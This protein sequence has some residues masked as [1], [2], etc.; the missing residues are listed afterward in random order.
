MPEWFKIFLKLL[1]LFLFILV[2]VALFGPS[3]E[4]HPLWWTSALYWALV[5]WA[6]VDPYMG[7]KSGPAYFLADTPENQRR[8][9]NLRINIFIIACVI[10]GLLAFVASMM[11]QGPPEIGPY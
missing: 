7:D 11:R 4:A 2:T 8:I 10:Y 9:Q 3:W 6:V 1:A 5:T